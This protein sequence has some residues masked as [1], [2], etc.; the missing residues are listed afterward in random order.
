[1]DAGAVEGFVDVDVAEAGEE[2]LVEEGGFDG[3]AGLEEKGGEAAGGDLEGFGAEVGVGTMAGFVEVEAAE[4]A[5][6]AKA[7]LCAARKIGD[8]QGFQSDTPGTSSPV[9][10]DLGPCAR[11]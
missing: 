3:A 9:A 5:G 7:E 4:T 11:P 10:H 6:V 2:G 8:D 1:M